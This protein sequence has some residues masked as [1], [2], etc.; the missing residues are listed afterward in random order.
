MTST[1]S[2]AQES[3]QPSVISVKHIP[4]DIDG[5]KI[6]WDDNPAYLAGALYE[7]SLFYERTGL[8]EALIKD[9]AVA[10]SNGK[11]AVD[12]AS[13]VSFVSG[14][15][16]DAAAHDFFHPCPPTPARITAYDAAQT[17]AGKKT[18]TA[19]TSVTP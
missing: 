11:L 15:T 17:A 13:A 2:T 5:N 9:G 6:E 10:L 8:F 1:I 19:P 16:A 12:S 18:F 4:T 14:I 3:E 7:C